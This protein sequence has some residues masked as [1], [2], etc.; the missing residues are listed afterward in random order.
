MRVA[1]IWSALTAAA[2]YSFG[3]HLPLIA[4]YVL[5]FAAGVF[6]VSAQTMVYAAVAHV[7]PTA[8]RATAIGR[9]TG[10]GRFGAVFGPR[11]GGQL[12][13]QPEL[14]FRHLCRGRAGGH[15]DAAGVEAGPGAHRAAGA[16]EG[17][18]RCEPAGRR[19]R[20]LSVD[21]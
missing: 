6:L 19:R 17:R 9:T 2:V 21:Y 5:V 12:L 16:G 14:G 3:A 7:Y 10:I 15:R 8:S 18:R 20:R 1:I 13:R 4:T 11:M